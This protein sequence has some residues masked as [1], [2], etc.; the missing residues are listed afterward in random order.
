MPLNK[1]ILTNLKIA[2]VG[3]CHG[4][5]SEADVGILSIIKPD[6]VL[7]VGDISDG[8]VKIIK[9]INLINI[10]TFVMLGNHDRGKDSTGET[11]S[12]Q[13]RV[14]GEKYCAWDLKVF[15]NQIN[16]LSARPCSSVSYTHLTLPTKRIV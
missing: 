7:F 5:W 3:D 9:K 6:I 15:N 14:L 12:K 8:S 1:K 10:P 11:L 4:L 13:I 16:L 2:I